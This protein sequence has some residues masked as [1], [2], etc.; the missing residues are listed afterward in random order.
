MS[1]QRIGISFI[2][3][4][5]TAACSTT[6][7]R[8][9]K[10]ASFALTSSYL[11]QETSTSPSQEP[12][13]IDVEE[14]GIATIGMSRLTPLPANRANFTQRSLLSEL[15][16]E[17]TLQV[18]IEAMPL[19]AYLHY[20]FSEQLELNY[21]LDEALKEDT[22]PVTLS[23]QEP[24]SQARLFEITNTL[25][26]KR[27]IAI[28]NNEGIYYVHQLD[29]SNKNVVI[30]VG[31][32]EISVPQ[33]AQKVLQVVPMVYGINISLERTLRELTDVQVTPDFAQNTLFLQGSRSEILKALEF[34]NMFDNP[35]NRSS[36]IGIV[37]LTFLT[38]DVFSE[39]IISLL[40]TEG[41]PVGQGNAQQKNVILI[42]LEQLGAVAVFASSEQLLSRVEYWASIIDK[43]GK[44][45]TEQYFT[46]RPD[47]A[48]ANDIGES[49]SA[50]LGSGTGFGSVSGSGARQGTSNNSANTS[51]TGNAPNASRTAGVMN[52]SMKMV[53]D[54]RAN[55]L[56][57]YTSGSEYQRILPLIREL[58]VLPKQVMLD[59][60]IAEVTLKDEFKFGVEWAVANN[61]VSLTTLGAF[62]AASVGGIGLQIN[63]S[64]GPLNA[65]A[66]ESSS[67]VKV[68]S[69]PTLLV[70]DGMTAN[71]NIG[72]SISVVGATTIDPINSVRQTTSTE[73]RETGVDIT[74]TP[75]VNAKGILIMEIQ[76]NISNTVPN[77]SG[78]GNNPDIF[79]RSLNTEVVASSGETILL[80]GLISEDVSD[81]GANVPGT[82]K[83]PVLGKLFGNQSDSKTRTELVM[84]ITPRVI[85][86]QQEWK[87]VGRKFEKGLKFLKIE[88]N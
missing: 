46:Y 88:T 5:L 16:K 37:E 62:G 10:E 83:V 19:G 79:E 13:T 76:Q 14:G 32:D 7:E 1:L 2:A 85:E 61:E 44:G 29:E 15:S 52:E 22:A 63:G 42:P 11:A 30:G 57:F 77:S 23:I 54:E 4:A 9:I 59:I 33:T 72:S 34:V 43:P 87:E 64:D 50:L 81:G 49:L 51:S 56:I 73:Y 35:A 69:N 67:L 3:C 38:S 41:V 20:V 28:T 55:K 82:T 17:P 24:I 26:N 71:I 47:F 40:E 45:S 75:T 58:D 25:L 78:A 66:F 39:Q 48:R 86:N 6:N 27:Q 18:A 53:V 84:L 74:V 8:G 70:R 68:L 80:G 31:R 12:V 65:S 21:V 36:H 60:T